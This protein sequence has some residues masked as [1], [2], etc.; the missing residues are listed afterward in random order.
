[1]AITCHAFGI[2]TVTVLQ[3]VFMTPFRFVGILPMPTLRSLLHP[4]L[5]HHPVLSTFILS[6]FSKLKNPFKINFDSTTLMQFK[7]KR[8]LFSTDLFIFFIFQDQT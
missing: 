4:L 1:M 8:A 6:D 7:L 2:K 3:T 5:I